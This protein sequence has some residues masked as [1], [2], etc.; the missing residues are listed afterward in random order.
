MITVQ[1]LDKFLDMCYTYIEVWNLNPFGR[2]AVKIEMSGYPQM[3]C[4]FRVYPSIA[5]GFCLAGCPFS[6]GGGPAR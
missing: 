2:G 4:F 6:I 1:V 5:E 3:P